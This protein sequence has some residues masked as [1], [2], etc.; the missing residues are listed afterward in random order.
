[1]RHTQ[2]V[3]SQLLFVRFQQEKVRLVGLGFNTIDPFVIWI[4]QSGCR[5]MREKHPFSVITHLDH[6][7][8]PMK[9]PT[10]NQYFFII[11]YF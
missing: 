4:S 1:M 11:F 9:T 8:Q 7:R 3:T 5:V 2:L 6:V 10:K